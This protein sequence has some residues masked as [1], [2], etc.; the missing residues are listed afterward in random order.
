VARAEG[1]D[2]E[3]DAVVQCV[4][5]E[6]CCLALDFITVDWV[7]V[8]PTVLGTLLPLVCHLPLSLA[9]CEWYRPRTTDHAIPRLMVPALLA[10]V[11]FVHSSL[12]H[13]TTLARACAEDFHTAVV[14]F[15]DTR[16]NRDLLCNRGVTDDP[17]TRCRQAADLE[18]AARQCSHA[19]ERMYAAFCSALSVHY[20][21]YKLFDWFI[22]LLRGS[23]FRSSRVV[24]QGDYWALL[25]LFHRTVSLPRLEANTRLLSRVVEM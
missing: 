4:L 15:Q 1:V 10:E 21:C 2:L 12:R 19:H 3:S 14:A 23:S 13:A 22:T 7:D 24:R 8:A 18:V 11:L 20:C 17:T 25:D 5:A 9:I 6:M 16:W